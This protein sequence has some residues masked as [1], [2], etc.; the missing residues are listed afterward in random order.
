MRTLLKKLA[1]VKEMVK[2]S[3]EEHRWLERKILVKTT[4][5]KFISINDGT[6]RVEDLHQLLIL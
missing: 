6:I 2:R 3:S 5:G 1:I 4:G